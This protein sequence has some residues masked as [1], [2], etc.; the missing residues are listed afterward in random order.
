VAEGFIKSRKIGKIHQN[1]VVFVKG[2]PVKAAAK[3]KID[4]QEL[5]D[6]LTSEAEAEAQ[7][8]TA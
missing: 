4:R 7:E 3:W 2:D 8:I 5:E 1:S 6:A